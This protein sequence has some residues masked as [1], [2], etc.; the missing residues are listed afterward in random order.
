[1]LWLAS[2]DKN[3]TFFH[4]VACARRSRKQIWEIEDDFGNLIHSQT[5]IKSVAHLHFK[6]F[7]Q[8]PPAPS[9]TDQTIVA[10]LFPS[11][12][13]PEEARSLLSPCTKTELFEIINS[14]KKEKSPGPDGWS[15]ELFLHFFELMCPDL[16]EVMEDSKSRGVVSSYLNKT[17]VVLIPK[18]NQPRLFSDFRPISLCNLC[19]K[20]ISKLIAVRL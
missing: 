3:T 4:K 20:I 14:F 19:Y 10:S 7:Y 16:L 18:A 17:Y 2:G 5:E 8:A 11:M 12:I 1:M 13:T 15:V 9:L 6:S